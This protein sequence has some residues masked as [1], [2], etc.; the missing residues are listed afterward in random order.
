MWSKSMTD[1]QKQMIRDAAVDGRLACA[2]AFRLS[3]ELDLSLMVIGAF[4]NEDG[5]RIEHCQL[6][7]FP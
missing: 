7:C 1:E 4:C 2:K 6:G 3:E 5:I